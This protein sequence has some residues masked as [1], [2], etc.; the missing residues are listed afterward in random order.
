MVKE[1]TKEQMLTKS[2]VDEAG[3]VL[4][5]VGRNKSLFKLKG[6]SVPLG[7]F[8]IKISDEWSEDKISMQALKSY[9]KRRQAY[10]ASHG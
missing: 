6:K 5:P 8:P 3:D 9:I 4:E 1:S 2:Q 7:C 10:L